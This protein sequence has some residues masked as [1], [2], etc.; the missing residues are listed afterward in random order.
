[1]ADFRNERNSYGEY[2]V[3]EDYPHTEEHYMLFDG[4]HYGTI[5]EL[6]NDYFGG[7]FDYSDNFYALLSDVYGNFSCSYSIWR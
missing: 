1:M 4:G 5:D 2:G 7:A 3:R 6:I